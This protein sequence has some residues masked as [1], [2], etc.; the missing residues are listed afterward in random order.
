VG[1]RDRRA[2]VTNRHNLDL[3]L[4]EEGASGL[5]LSDVEIDLHHVVGNVAYPETRFFS[6]INPTSCIRLHPNADCA[7]LADPKFDCSAEFKDQIPVSLSELADR[8][9]LREKVQIMDFASFIGFPGSDEAPWLDEQATLPI[10][11]MASIAST[12]ERAFVNQG[13]LTED[14]VLV[15]GFSFS[16]SSGS[17]VFSHRKG[18]RAT[19]PLIADFVP[20]KL[21][22]IMS[23]HRVEA[24]ILPDMLDHTGLSYSHPVN[25]HP[26]GSFRFAG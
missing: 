17:L 25:Q 6:V 4:R 22:G 16:G 13:I 21:V 18:L 9:F 26:G 10:A 11:R 2:F 19:P 15:S 24:G 7:V 20:A 14:V 23:G 1:R 3:G 8:E 12:P 5:Q